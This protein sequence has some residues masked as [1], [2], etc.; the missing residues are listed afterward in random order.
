M[1]G[2]TTT[3]RAALPLTTREET[4]E[5]ITVATATATGTATA[6]ALVVTARVAGHSNKLTK[7]RTPLAGMGAGGHPNP[8]E[9]LILEAMAPP[10]KG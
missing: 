7:H 3:P 2:G 4:V 8:E 5:A 10:G 6:Q 9:T 1:D